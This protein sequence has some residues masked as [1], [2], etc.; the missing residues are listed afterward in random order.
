M[1]GFCTGRLAERTAY[2]YR[3]RRE[4]NLA[5]AQSTMTRSRMVAMAS[6]KYNRW[7]P[8]MPMRTTKNTLGGMTSLTQKKNELTSLRRRAKGVSKAKATG[9]VTD[10]RARPR[11]RVGRRS[12]VL[13]ELSW[14][15]G[16][17]QRCEG[18]SRTG[19]GW[20]GW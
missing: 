7:I 10:D 2:Q 17:L 6:T 1:P 13:C 15:R 19:G 5:R 16:A 18:F 20:D 3:I 14:T 9:A 11:R 8:A 4:S 12:C